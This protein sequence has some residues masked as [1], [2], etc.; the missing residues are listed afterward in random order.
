VVGVTLPDCSDQ[1][2]PEAGAVAVL[3][4][5]FGSFLNA[6]RRPPKKMR[7]PPSAVRM[8]S[9][10]LLIPSHPVTIGVAWPTLAAALTGV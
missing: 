1:A 5:S 6:P 2:V 4:E 7:S 3:R 9:G 10:W 8:R